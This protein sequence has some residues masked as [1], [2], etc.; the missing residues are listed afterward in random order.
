MGATTPGRSGPG[1]DGNKGVLGI[2]QSTRITGASPSDCLV[3]YPGQSLAVV[4][5][6]SRDTVS[7]F[8][9]PSQLSHSLGESYPS[10][11]MQLVYST[12]AD[13]AKLER[14]HPTGI[15]RNWNIQLRLGFELGSLVPFPGVITVT[16][17][18]AHVAD[19]FY[20]VRVSQW[21]SIIRLLAV[22][23][24]PLLFWL[25]CVFAWQLRKNHGWSGRMARE[26]ERERERWGDSQG[27]L[28]RCHA[29][30]I[31]SYFYD[32]SYL[33][34]FTDPCRSLLI[35]YLCGESPW[36]SD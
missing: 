30:M 9:S 8:Y 14:K 2:P 20:G 17:R 12:E 1:S 32:I 26:R 34:R 11:N 10:A 19:H 31:M 36:H 6:H 5:L 3:S 15:S 33:S 7:V 18:A 25:V 29:L 35:V 21:I 27:N 28:C 24:C 22:E 23:S 4:L 16:L 13:G